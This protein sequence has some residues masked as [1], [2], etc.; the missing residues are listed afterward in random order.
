MGT[1][2]KLEPDIRKTA[3]TPVT[4]RKFVFYSPLLFTARQPFRW[5]FH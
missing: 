4:P 3:R 1:V 2:C 5:H